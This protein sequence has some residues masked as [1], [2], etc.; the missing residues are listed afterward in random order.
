MNLLPAVLLAVSTFVLRAEGPID[1][2]TFFA[3]R[4]SQVFQDGTARA[5]KSGFVEGAEDASVL[6]WE[7]TV[8]GQNL[9]MEVRNDRLTLITGKGKRELRFPRAIALRVE[10]RLVM[11]PNNAELHVTDG[12]GRR[13]GVLCI[14][15]YPQDVHRSTPDKEA[16]VVVDPVGRP[17]LYRMPKR[18]ASALGLVRLGE[19]AYGLPC[20]TRRMGA[21]ER[22]N[23]QYYRL[24]EG[25]LRAEG[26]PLAVQYVPGDPF[27]FHILP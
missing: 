16:Y 19:D 6:S 2:G 20:F 11:D 26:P 22:W 18:H 10:P 14:E 5:L 4:P 25:G 3:S 27:R 17:R 7:G 1:V 23:I 13:P 8:D 9:Y 12:Q 24:T 15:A 21:T